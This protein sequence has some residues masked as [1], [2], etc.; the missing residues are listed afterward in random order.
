MNSAT[1]LFSFVFNGCVLLVSGLIHVLTLRCFKA[2]GMLVRDG[3]Y[4]IVFKQDDPPVQ[5]FVCH[6]PN[7]QMQFSMLPVL[8]TFS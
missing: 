5:M 6:K 4:S 2:L 3:Q 7:A 1:V 8:R